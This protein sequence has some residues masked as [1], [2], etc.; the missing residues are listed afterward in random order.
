MI[1]HIFLIC[2]LVIEILILELEFIA[3]RK[4]WAHFEA[5]ILTLNLQFK[6]L[7]LNI[8]FLANQFIAGKIFYP[9]KYS[10]N[11]DLLKKFKFEHRQHHL[12]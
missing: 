10:A 4:C 5:E 8:Q 11:P 7:K 3:E 9:F 1:F 12:Q 2:A 6:F